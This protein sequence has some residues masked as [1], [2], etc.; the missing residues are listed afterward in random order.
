MKSMAVISIT[1]EWCDMIIKNRERKMGYTNAD[2][3][4]IVAKQE[5]YEK[6]ISQK[7]NESEW[8]GFQNN[9]GG[10][11]RLKVCRE[12]DKSGNYNFHKRSLDCNEQNLTAV[13]IIVFNSDHIY[14]NPID[15]SSEFSKTKEPKITIKKAKSNWQLWKSLIWDETIIEVISATNVHYNRILNRNENIDKKAIEELVKQDK[16]CCYCGISQTQIDTLEEFSKGNNGHQLWCFDYG[17]TK[18][19]YRKT[20][21]IDQKNP[22]IGYVKDNIVWACSWCNNAKTDTFTYEEFKMIAKNINCVWNKR[23]S[24][25]GSTE[26]AIYPWTEKAEECFEDNLK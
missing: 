9:S 6:Q 14:Y 2:I 26:R 19:D 16:K 10:I 12:A 13:Y 5:G 20:L 1:S 23:L 24:Q 8:Y 15:C 11:V 25:T 7:R 21:E 22:T 3:C 4:E 17:L 18:R